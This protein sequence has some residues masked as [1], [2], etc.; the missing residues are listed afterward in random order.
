MEENKRCGNIV[1]SVI[2]NKR[3]ETES[4]GSRDW[5]K[6]KDKREEENVEKRKEK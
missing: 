2:K 1:W 6:Q 3:K 5:W 4:I